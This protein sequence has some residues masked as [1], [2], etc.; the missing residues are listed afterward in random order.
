MDSDGFDSHRARLLI[1]RIGPGQAPRSHLRHILLRMQGS[2]KSSSGQS[3][4]Q[5]VILWR[6]GALGLAI[7]GLIMMGIGASGLSGVPISLALLTLGFACL[8]AG[9]VLPRIE[10]KFT[11]GTSGVSA[12][13]LPVHKLDSVTYTVSA[14]AVATVE[15]DAVVGEETATAL[16]EEQVKLGDVWDAL[17]GAGFHVTQ[18]AT[19]KRL[20]EGPEGR[21]IMLH[22]RE[23][24]GWAIA[25]KD[26]L[27][28]LASWGIQPVASG[29]YA[30][31]GG[32]DPDYARRPYS[33]V[34]LPP[35]IE[36]GQQQH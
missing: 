34:P 22:G 12:E 16:A 6:Y 27:A 28:Q 11:A 26:L 2:L 15:V 20:L 5:Y 19:G 24:L 18:A 23:L 36:S 3:R 13:L 17:E 4:W 8:I 7:V 21:S 31:P 29:I 30:V 35:R 1:R 10:G 14:P 33:G 9:V 32:V 25:S